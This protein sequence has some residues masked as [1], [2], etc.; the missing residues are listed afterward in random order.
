MFIGHY[1]AAFLTKKVDRKINL[2]VLFFLA[3]LPDT[4]MAVLVLLG[5]EKFA[6]VKGITKANPL[7]LYHY[8]ISHGLA[9]NVILTL[10]VFFIVKAIYKSARTGVAGGLAVFSHFV[11]DF[12]THRPD[13]PLLWGD[14]KIGLG[15]WN[16]L[17]WSIFVE[18]SIFAIGVAVYFSV[19]KEQTKAKK[20]GMGVL[21]MVLFGSYIM[22]MI[23]GAEPPSPNAL[24]VTNLI[25]AVIFVG[26]AI[27]LDK[28]KV[29]T[30]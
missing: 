15:L 23:G 16:H 21:S 28:T 3:T 2:G 7:D 17:F 24:A 9:S 14:P 11:L 27:W 18:A 20:I 8:P 4:L 5:V 6:I 30:H 10:L 26:L 12:I 19:V 25:S 13:L 22:T 29:K 1:G